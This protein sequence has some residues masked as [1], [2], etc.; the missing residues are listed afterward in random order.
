METGM[1]IESRYEIW[2]W[3]QHC[4]FH[5]LFTFVNLAGGGKGSGQHGFERLCGASAQFGCLRWDYTDRCDRSEFPEP[6]KSFFNGLCCR[7][8]TAMSLCWILSCHSAYLKN[9]CFEDAACWSCSI[10]ETFRFVKHVRHQN[11]HIPQL[12]WHHHTL[13]CHFVA[14]TPLSEPKSDHSPGIATIGI[15]PS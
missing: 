14:L 9:Q 8:A 3:K 1:S 10:G 15:L 5:F 13:P 12:A 7:K 11:T 6:R 2:L 4:L